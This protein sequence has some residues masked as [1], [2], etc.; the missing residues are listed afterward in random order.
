M[1]RDAPVFRTEKVSYWAV[2][3]P[4][5]GD[6]QEKWTYQW[7]QQNQL[8]QVT[9]KSGH[10]SGMPVATQWVVEYRYCVT[11][12]AQRRVHRDAPVFCTE[13]VSYWDSTTPAGVG[14]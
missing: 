10:K 6:E 9:Y 12:G 3:S 7:N 2:S 5:A 8:T 13:K 4:G 14:R 1:H 11:C